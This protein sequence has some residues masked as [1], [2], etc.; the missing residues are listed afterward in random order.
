MKEI[1]GFKLTYKLESE[2]TIRSHILFNIKRT[3]FQHRRL[4]MK[5]FNVK[6]C[7]VTEKEFAMKSA[8]DAK[9]KTTRGRERERER[10]REE[11]KRGKE[12]TRYLGHPV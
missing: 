9:R 3:M 12:S 8:T 4:I 10:E 11:K 6:N 2:W 5:I 1:F 7:E